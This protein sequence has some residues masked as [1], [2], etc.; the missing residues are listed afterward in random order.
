MKRM[1]SVLG[2][3]MLLVSI[4]ASVQATGDHPALPD[5]TKAP[6]ALIGAGDEGYPELH[7]DRGP[8]HVDVYSNTGKERTV[9][10][11]WVGLFTDKDGKKSYAESITFKT[12]CVRGYDLK[13]DKW[14]YETEQCPQ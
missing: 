13:G 9:D 8:L 6:F 14:V 10:T 1:L 5:Y 12:G 2:I 3:L 4:G 7:Q 11:T